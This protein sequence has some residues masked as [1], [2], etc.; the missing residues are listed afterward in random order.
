MSHFGMQISCLRIVNHK[1]S[2]MIIARTA[3]KQEQVVKNNSKLETIIFFPS[4]M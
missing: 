3:G 1:N 2:N 4:K